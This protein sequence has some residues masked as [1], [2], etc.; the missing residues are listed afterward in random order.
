NL[1]DHDPLTDLRNR[2]AFEQD[3][4]GHVAFVRRYGAEGALLL[5]GLDGL[6]E[7]TSVLGAAEADDLLVALADAVVDRLR[8][9]DVVCRWATD[10]LAILVPRARGDHAQR[11]A[12]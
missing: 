3:L 6:V 9:T 2:R 10:E 11:V 4:E 1:A 5:V 7:V 12:D 8:T